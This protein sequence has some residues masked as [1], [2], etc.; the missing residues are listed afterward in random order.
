MRN[1]NVNNLYDTPDTDGIG[2]HLVL[3]N[4]K[5]CGGKVSFWSGICN[6]VKPEFG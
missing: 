4:S 1:I 6:C 2:F 5:S 3:Q